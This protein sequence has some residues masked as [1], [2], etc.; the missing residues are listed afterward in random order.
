MA[1]RVPGH[2]GAHLDLGIHPNPDVGSSDKHPLTISEDQVPEVSA[3]EMR[4][5]LW[6]FVPG[7]LA[8]QMSLCHQPL[9]RGSLPC[10]TTKGKTIRKIRRSVSL[11]TFRLDMPGVAPDGQKPEHALP[12]SLGLQGW[13]GKLRKEVCFPA[14]EPRNAEVLCSQEDTKRC[15]YYYLA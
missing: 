1:T 5:C 7:F 8:H 12:P 2:T 6:R 4:G 14:K 13:L 9:P 15:L 10:R 11:L 3:G